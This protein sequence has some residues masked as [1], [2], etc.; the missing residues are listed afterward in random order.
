MTRELVLEKRN[1]KGPTF[2]S[3]I[4][5]KM[6]IDFTSVSEWEYAKGPRWKRVDAMSMGIFSDIKR[7][8]TPQ[9]VVESRRISNSFELSLKPASMKKL[10]EKPPRKSDNTVFP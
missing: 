9:S 10:D 1:T 8:L 4:G 5:M 2:L 6:W 3:K 7:Q